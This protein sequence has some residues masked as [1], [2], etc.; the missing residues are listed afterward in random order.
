MPGLISDIRALVKYR[1]L[2]WE[3][4]IKDIEVRYRNPV[5]GSLWAIITPLITVLIFKLVFS[6]ILKIE[7][8]S[9]PFFIYLMTAVFPWTYFSC[10]VSAATESILSNR[11]LI[12]K[13]YFPR[14]IIPISVVLA[15]LLNFIPAV[16]VMLILL[17]LFKMQFTIAIFLLP[18]IIILQT[19]LAIGLALILSSLQ[20]ILRDMK[21]IVEIGLMAWFYLSPGFYSLMLVA[22]ISGA[23]FKIYMLNPF[24]GLFILYRMAFLKG[25][26]KTLPPNIN[27]P[28]LVIWTMIFC[29]AMF[30]LGL[31]IF[32]KYEKRFSDLI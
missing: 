3:L 1:N 14:H 5:L 17:F 18:L 25:Y 6:D 24:V 20:V 2:L 32:K 27:I 11:E 16:I 29:L 10:S 13:T 26:L 31:V 12:K 4:A 30:F 22:N 8:E 9:Y 23:F 15:N 7:A 19:I 21:Y 28:G